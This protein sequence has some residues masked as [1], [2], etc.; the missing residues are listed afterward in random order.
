MNLRENT[1][2]NVQSHRQIVA[3]SVSGS[4]V[5]RRYLIEWRNHGKGLT[6]VDILFASYRPATGMIAQELQSDVMGFAKF[7]K[8]IMIFCGSATSQQAI[9][10]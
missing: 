10:F 5:R 3:F 4:F 6:P 7:W 8:A 9:L 1:D 2:N